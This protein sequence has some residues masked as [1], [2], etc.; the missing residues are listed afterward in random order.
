MAL[1]IRGVIGFLLG[2]LSII[3]LALWMEA[4]PAAAQTPASEAP[5]KVT[6][7]GWSII[8]AC[9]MPLGIAMVFSDGKWIGLATAE[10][11]DELKAA[12]VMSGLEPYVIT[13]C[14]KEGGVKQVTT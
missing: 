5:A 9:R 13:V 4:V 14:S 1:S 11:T 7:V 10:I 12:I 8:K 3:A 6:L 2:F